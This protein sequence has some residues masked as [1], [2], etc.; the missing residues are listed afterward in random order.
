[1]K[2]FKIIRKYHKAHIIEEMNKLSS[3]GYELVSYTPIED[4]GHSGCGWDVLMSIDE[5]NSPSKQNT[6]LD[7]AKERFCSYAPIRMQRPVF[8]EALQSG[9]AYIDYDGGMRKVHN[10]SI[11]TDGY[12]IQVYVDGFDNPFSAVELK[13][14]AYLKRKCNL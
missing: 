9:L 11:D 5:E 10:C 6:N 3:D 1:M 8:K 4:N 14:R 12:I 7:I 2:K 13:H